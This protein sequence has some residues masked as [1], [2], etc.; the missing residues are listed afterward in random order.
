[1][2][3]V[4]TDLRVQKALLP[5]LDRNSELLQSR[6]WGLFKEKFGWQSHACGVR[7]GSAESTCLLLS[8]NIAGG[9]RIVYVPMGPLLLPP[10]DRRENLLTELAGQLESLLPAGTFC[11][12]YDLPWERPEAGA[13]L[14]PSFRFRKSVVDIQP[15]S[16]V[17]LDLEYG[18]EELLRRM[19]H[20]TR[21]NIRLSFRKGVT[22]AEAGEER[23]ED[24]F[25]LHVETSRR[26]LIVHRSFPYFQTQ[27]QL[28][29]E[30]GADAPVFRLF[31]A[32]HED[33]LLS[34]IIVAFYMGRAWY[35]Y[36]ASGSRKRNLMP[37]FALQW[38]AIQVA[39]SR[40]CRSYDFFGIPAKPDPDHPMFGLYQFKTGFGGGIVH[41][42]GCW[43]AVL[44][45]PAYRI[46]RTADALRTV[47]FQKIRKRLAD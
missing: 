44:K 6:F 8:K 20:K 13:S 30:L 2:N 21:Y 1:M 43:D 12:R 41:R 10:D 32:S 26:D 7:L 15:S 3:P 25:R 42:F 28:A 22:V 29:R 35:L 24:W 27:F 5:D 4:F 18:E 17:V 11:V 9:H 37:N 38:R 39:I 19:K 34:G 33:E 16:T 23:L 36:G 46:F 45:A 47:Y 31:L 14:K 40:D